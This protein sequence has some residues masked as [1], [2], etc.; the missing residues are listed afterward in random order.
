MNNKSISPKAVSAQV[1]RLGEKID[2]MGCI[3]TL[4]DGLWSGI[5]CWVNVFWLL[6]KVFYQ[7]GLLFET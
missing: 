1:L 6:H 4:F 5:P 7:K 3:S 2:T